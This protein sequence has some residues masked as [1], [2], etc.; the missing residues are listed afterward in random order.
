[1]LLG[2]GITVAVS[3]LVLAVIP[4][5]KRAMRS[6]VEMLLLLVKREDQAVGDL[7]AVERS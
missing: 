3:F 4:A 1:L 2:F 6:S 5:G 7:A